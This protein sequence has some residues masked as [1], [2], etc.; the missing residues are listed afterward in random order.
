M[1]CSHHQRR[2]IAPLVRSPRLHSPRIGRVATYTAIVCGGSKYTYPSSSS[3]IPSTHPPTLD[4]STLHLFPAW[5]CALWPS[6]RRS[7]CGT[8]QA[9][10]W[11]WQKG[12]TIRCHKGGWP[13]LPLG[14]IWRQH[15]ARH[16][17]YGELARCKPRLHGLYASGCKLPGCHCRPGTGGV[18]GT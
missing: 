5:A 13:E 8:L 12:P 6:C 4:K 11:W 14:R 10:P 1:G 18:P 7:E 16:S 2:G 15:K 3:C 9:A 17:C